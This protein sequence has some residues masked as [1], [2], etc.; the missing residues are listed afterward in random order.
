M[1]PFTFKDWLFSLFK[2]R[3]LR[4]YIIGND[5]DWMIDRNDNVGLVDKN[6]D[7]MLNKNSIMKCEDCR[8]LFQ[9]EDIY[10]LLSITHQKEDKNAIS[11][12]ASTDEEE[13]WHTKKLSKVNAHYYCK[14][15][16]DTKDKN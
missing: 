10:E 5:C 7:K 2:D 15:C 11:Y 13:E 6:I 8:A 12:S 9:K 14:K 3:N 16:L 1:N 4:R